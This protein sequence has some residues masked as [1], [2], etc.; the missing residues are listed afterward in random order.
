MHRQDLI[1]ASE[2][3]LDCHLPNCVYDHTCRK[4]IFCLRDV[5]CCRLPHTIIPC[6]TTER[7]AV[8]VIAMVRDCERCCLSWATKI[9]LVEASPPLHNGL[10]DFCQLLRVLSGC[11]QRFHV[12]ITVFFISPFLYIAMAFCTC[13]LP[14]GLPSDTSSGCFLSSNDMLPHPRA[15]LFDFLTCAS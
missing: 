11:L 14:F 3:R 2:T 4:T 10:V 1:H 5:H 8:T 9:L 12:E 7:K 15:K 13:V 6:T